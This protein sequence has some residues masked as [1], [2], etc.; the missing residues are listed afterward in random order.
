[1]ALLPGVALLPCVTL[2]SRVTRLA[3]VILLGPVIRRSGII[4]RAGVILR[5][6]VTLLTRIAL[7]GI[8]LRF[9]VALLSLLGPPYWRLLIRM[10]GSVPVLALAS[11]IRPGRRKGL[12]R[13]LRFLP[14]IRLAGKRLLARLVLTCRISRQA[15]R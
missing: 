13:L 11:G 7:A 6:R 5:A 3:L 1:V 9:G 8:G 15:D 12:R 14:R 10:P 2:L 4:L